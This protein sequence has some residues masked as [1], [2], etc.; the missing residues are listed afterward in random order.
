MADILKLGKSKYSLP[1]PPESLSAAVEP[2]SLEPSR[3]GEVLRIDSILRAP[4]LAEGNQASED[5]KHA[6]RA[7]QLEPDESEEIED[8]TAEVAL[9]ATSVEETKYECLPTKCCFVPHKAPT[10]VMGNQT[11]QLF[12]PHHPSTENIRLLRYTDEV[13][14][15]PGSRL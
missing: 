5:T 2:A 8:F 11:S 1:K 14:L 4:D 15:M 7:P 9:V 12:R 6:L 10:S 13:S 3:V